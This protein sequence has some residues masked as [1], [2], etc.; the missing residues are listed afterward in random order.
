MLDLSRKLEKY[1]PG[2][3]S[4]SMIDIRKAKTMWADY[5]ADHGAARVPSRLLTAPADN[6]KLKKTDAV[7]YSLSLAPADTS[8]Y[9][10]CRFSTPVCRSGCV[11][12]SG[13][14][15]FDV[16]TEGRV[17]KTRFLAEHT[18]A[19]LTLLVWEL[20]LAVK[21]HG[22]INLRLNTFSDLRWERITPWLF[23]M[24]QDSITF[25]DYTKY[26]GDRRDVPSN[27]RLTYSVH[28]RDTEATV[29]VKLRRGPA[30]VVFDTKR[31]A[32]LPDSYL[33]FPVVDGDQTD[34]RTLDSAGVV[35]G[36]RA[37]GGLIGDTSGFVKS[38]G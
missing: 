8:G 17:R 18:D 31:M 28:E 21:R 13:N 30:A 19:F 12:F 36:L 16:V 11:A 4:Q 5:R 33:G 23:T 32:K 2:I 38:G 15:R 37:K 7:T 10:V 24:F 9:N 1:Q 26:P 20:G 22:R 3:P 29:M 27:Y 6:T 35:V 34:D 25:Y 14:G